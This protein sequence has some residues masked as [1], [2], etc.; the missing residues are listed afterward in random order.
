MTTAAARDLVPL[1][2]LDGTNPLGFLASLGVLRCLDV[3]DP[4]SSPRLSFSREQA[5]PRLHLASAASIEQIAEAC[6]RVLRELFAGGLSVTDYPS[7]KLALPRE[8]FRSLAL[9]RRDTA[10]S[11]IDQLFLH[12]LAAASA[13]AVPDADE[14]AVS[15]ISFANGQSNFYLLGGSRQNTSGRTMSFQGVRTIAADDRLPDLLSDALTTGTRHPEFPS[16]R[17]CPTEFRPAAHQGE[18]TTLLSVP[19][20]NA[21]AVIGLSFFPLAPTADGVR[22]VGMHHESRSSSLLMPHWSTPLDTSAVHSLITHA[23]S[24]LPLGPRD[25]EAVG[26]HA[27]LAAERF[28]QNKGV[29]FAPAREV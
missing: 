3:A 9:R 22:S 1:P 10:A 12:W 21:L 5:Q 7:A 23:E 25:R 20:A 16:F 18:E 8:E 4:A 24:L 28:S 6:A 14:T 29:Y 13:Q 15:E 27:I 11:P 26:V 19:G 17:W 2:G